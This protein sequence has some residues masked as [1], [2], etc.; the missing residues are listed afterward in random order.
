MPLNFKDGQQKS[1]ASQMQTAATFGGSQTLLTKGSTK[2][3]M[4]LY[5]TDQFSVDEESY[6]Y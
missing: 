3:D 2:G 1:C 4:S 6:K 5:G